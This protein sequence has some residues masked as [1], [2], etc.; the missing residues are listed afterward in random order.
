MSIFQTECDDDVGLCGENSSPQIRVDK[1]SATD[2]IYV[3][4]LQST[5]HGHFINSYCTQLKT[6]K[7]F[8]VRN[9]SNC[10]FFSMKQLKLLQTMK[11]QQ[12]WW[13]NDIV[14]E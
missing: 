11:Q 2:P 6:F 13:E 3:I 5:I 9:Q 7:I 1:G 4:L 10:E 14:G 12:I 8:H